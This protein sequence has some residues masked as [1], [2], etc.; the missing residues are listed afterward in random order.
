MVDIGAFRISCYG[1]TK[2][3]AQKSIDLPA[4]K[5]IYLLA[6]KSFIFLARKSFIFSRENPLSSPAKMVSSSC[7]KNK[8]RKPLNLLVPKNLLT[9]TLTNLQFYESLPAY[10]RKTKQTIYAE[11]LTIL[12]NSCY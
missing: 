9:S 5:S 11:C 4:Q 3:L 10:P 8:P 12:K 6:R 1:N 2:P 7:L